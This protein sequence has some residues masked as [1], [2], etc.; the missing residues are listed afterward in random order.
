M[1]R[2]EVRNVADKPGLVRALRAAFPALSN[3]TPIIEWDERTTFVLLPAAADPTPVVAAVDSFFANPPGPPPD[4]RARVVTELA[5][6]TTLLQ[7]KTALQRWL[8]ESA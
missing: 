4:Y 2:V 7:L 1:Q 6:A 8:Q 3:V 5:A